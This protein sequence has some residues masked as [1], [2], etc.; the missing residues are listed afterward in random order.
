MD[1]LFWVARVLGLCNRTRW[2]IELAF[3]GDALMWFV[4]ALDA[5]LLVVAFRREKFHDL[6]GPGDA[7]PAHRTP[8][9]LDALSDLELVHFHAALFF[10]TA[11]S[12]AAAQR[13]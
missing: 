10:Q 9:V 11:E 8:G 2:A 12:S 7:D 4:R 13:A 3:L 5:I 6:E 1:P